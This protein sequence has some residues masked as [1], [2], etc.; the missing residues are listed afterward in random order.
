[1]NN[2]KM[3][4]FSK[5]YKVIQKFLN[6]KSIKNRMMKNLNDNIYKISFS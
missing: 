6:N 2:L 5:I 1:M 4:K 3:N